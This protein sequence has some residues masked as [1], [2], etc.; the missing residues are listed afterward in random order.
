MTPSSRDTSRPGPEAA[1]RGRN[2]FDVCLASRTPAPAGIARELATRRS[3]ATRCA[4]APRVVPARG[5]TVDV[6]TGGGAIGRPVL[7]LTPVVIRPVWWTGT[8][9]RFSGW[10]ACTGRIGSSAV[11]VQRVHEQAAGRLR[12]EPRR[13]RRHHLAAVADRHQL[14]DGGRR[15]REGRPGAACGDGVGEVGQGGGP[16]GEGGGGGVGPTGEGERGVGARVRDPKQ[17]REHP[18]LEKADRQPL[19]AAGRWCLRTQAQPGP[20]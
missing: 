9:M 17:G 6:V 7:L 15:E 3:T 14:V 10:P 18:V 20:D 13:L 8:T 4:I 12:V 16:T 1:A 5:G 2:R 19:D 11:S